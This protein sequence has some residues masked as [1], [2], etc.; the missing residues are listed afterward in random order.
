MSIIQSLQKPAKIGRVEIEGKNRN[1]DI[2]YKIFVPEGGHT[3]IDELIFH[4][5]FI[6]LI[7]LGPGQLTIGRFS[8]YEFGGDNINGRA[9][10]IR[11]EETLVR[12]NTPTRPYDVCFR[13]NNES[14]EE[15]LLRHGEIVHDH[16]LLTFVKHPSFP[17]SEVIASYHVDGVAQF[18]SVKADGY[19]VDHSGSI[20]NII[21][22]S[23]D[24]EISGKNSQ[25]FIFSEADDASDIHIGYKKYRVLL[26]D[27]YKYHSIFNTLRNSTIGCEGAEVSPGTSIRIKAVKETE[28]TSG[29]NTLLGFG[30]YIECDHDHFVAAVD[31]TGGDI[32]QQGIDGQ[33]AA[34]IGESQIVEGTESVQT[35]ENDG[36]GHALPEFSQELKED[37]D[38]ST[39]SQTIVP[40][41]KTLEDYADELQV[42]ICVLEAIKYQESKGS[43]FYKWRGKHNGRAT[44]LFERHIFYRQLVKHGVD[45]AQLIAERPELKDIIGLSQY[46]KY[47][48]DKT[49]QDRFDLACTVHLDAAI[50][51]PS[52]GEFQVLGKWWKMCG[53]KSAED[54][55]NNMATPEGQ[56]HAF[57]GYLRGCN[58]M[59]E[60]IRAK[61]WHQMK[62]LYNGPKFQ[63]RNGDGE[64]DWTAG[65]IR[66][67]TKAVQ[68]RGPRKSP[69]KSD[70]LVSNG[71][72]AILE[73]SVLYNL[74]TNSEAITAGAAN[75][76]RGG[77]N[78][79]DSVSQSVDSVVQSIETG[80]EAVG[81]VIDSATQ[82][83]EPVIKMG[84]QLVF[85]Q[86]AATGSS[87]VTY[88]VYGILFLAILLHGRVMWAYLNDN[89]YVLGRKGLIAC[90]ISG[91]KSLSKRGRGDVAT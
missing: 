35:A 82:I 63:D 46:Q 20:S 11:I 79:I 4:N 86:D 68:R 72:A 91:I 40:V 48:K 15:C 26:P 81:K 64:D 61:D 59:I 57:I 55:R 1:D 10:N 52:W 54:F 18:Y 29:N 2:G 12:D 75:L 25:A 85:A 88:A 28:F 44:K 13:K 58:G 42:D 19:T 67:Y 50:E 7:K 38:M 30:E 89:G 21:M 22:P 16:R 73:G 24:A 17:D 66:E 23:V 41:D 70:T 14:V 53:F 5:C 43:G 77:K 83:S 36:T 49:Q 76:V 33:L 37:P 27:G 84:D 8:G 45:P 65:V 32:H 31:S 3:Q 69:L 74:A 6:N 71:T 78:A 51:S 90:T 80:K 47:G 39:M 34:T 9:S 56:L 60:A 87:V 62:I